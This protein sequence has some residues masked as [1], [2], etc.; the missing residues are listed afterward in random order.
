[1]VQVLPFSA[2]PLFLMLSFPVWIALAGALFIV[3]RWIKSSTKSLPEGIREPPGS[4]G[5]PLVFNLTDI[6]AF[7]SWL[8][9]KEWS[10]QQGPISKLSIAGA[11]HV[12]VSTEK[13]ANDLT[14]EQVTLYSD[15]EQ[16]SMA[17]QLLPTTCGPCSYPT[18]PFCVEEESL[19]TTCR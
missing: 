15:R 12:V 4:G 9:Y 5:K 19:C 8:E 11:A 17:A 13:I 14:R 7:H 6:S 2:I 1:M 16:L 3:L 10:D 18:T